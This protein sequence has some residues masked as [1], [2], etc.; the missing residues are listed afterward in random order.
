MADTALGDFLKLFQ[1]YNLQYMCSDC[2][3][4]KGSLIPKVYDK[5]LHYLVKHHH[6]K[7]NL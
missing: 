3:F 7:S 6:Q 5:R 1:P 2:N 4:K